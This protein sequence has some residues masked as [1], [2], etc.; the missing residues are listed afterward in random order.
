MADD[1]RKR[2][3]T[4]AQARSDERRGLTVYSVKLPAALCAAFKA[5]CAE[6]GIS[7]AAA[8]SALMEGAITGAV[9]QRGFW[10]RLWWRLR[11]R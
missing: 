3:R 9:H 8:L 10:S 4:A 5:T 1:E 11:R 7:Q 6:Q 2:A